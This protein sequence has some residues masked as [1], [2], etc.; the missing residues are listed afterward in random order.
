MRKIRDRSK[1]RYERA[2][3]T[4]P[5]RHTAKLREAY[6]AAA[7]DARNVAEEWDT[8]SEEAWAMLDRPQRERA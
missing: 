6:I 3:F 8:A 5:V 1:T 2:I 4:L 7:G